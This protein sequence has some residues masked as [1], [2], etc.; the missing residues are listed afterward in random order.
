M[1]D[2]YS[3]DHNVLGFVL[4]PL[5]SGNYHFYKKKL[6][7]MFAWSGFQAIPKGHVKACYLQMLFSVRHD[8]QKQT[9]ATMG[10]SKLWGPF[11]GS[12]CHKACTMFADEFPPAPLLEI[13][14]NTKLLSI[15]STKSKC[16]TSMMTVLGSDI[17]LSQ[18]KDLP[19]DSIGLCS[20][21][22]R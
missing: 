14:Q 6:K 18:G 20:P 5:I 3:E 11:C 1:R 12:V 17:I 9:R 7:L 19:Q 2:P 22:S 21:L 13:A 10:V 15:F 16:V 4:G 8:F